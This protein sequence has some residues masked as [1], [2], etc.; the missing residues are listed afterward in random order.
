[1]ILS[2]NTGGNCNGSTP[3]FGEGNFENTNTCGFVSSAGAPNFPNTNPSLGP[4]QDNGGPTRTM[5]LRPGSPAIDAVSS[6]IRV[7]CQNSPDQRGRPRGRPHTNNG[8]DDV[9]LCDAGAFEAVEPFQVNT[10]AD[11]VDA[12]VNDDKCLTAGG[13][14]TLRAAIQQANAL[15]ASYEI[16]LPPGN[17]VLSIPGTGENLGAT[18]DLDIDPPIEIRAPGAGATTVSGGR[19]DR[20]GHR[21]AVACRERQPGDQIR[22]HH[23]GGRRSAAAEKHAAI[24][25]RDFPLERRRALVAND[26]T[27]GSEIRSTT[28]RPS[29][30]DRRCA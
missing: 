4:L 19:L 23:H 27:R 17:H 2:Q 21:V 10:L 13:L 28:G 24:L 3:S 16:V 25:L 6:L 15:P 20:V 12:N 29:A 18:G 7:N 5:A 1:M 26:E 14:C 9:F 22:T 30:G 8:V 11:G